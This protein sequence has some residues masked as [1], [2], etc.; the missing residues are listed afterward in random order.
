MR[1]F[2]ILLFSCLAF[3]SKA[4][5]KIMLM[6]GRILNVKNISLSGYTIAYR[7]LE[8]DKLRKIDTEKV[9]AIQYADGTE[10]LVFTPNPADTNEYTIPQMRMFIKGEQDATMYYK[11]NLNKGVAFAIG[12]GSSLLAIYGLV[13][14]PAY[15]TIIGAFSPNMEKMQVSDSMLLNDLDYRDGYKSKVRNRK[16]RNSLLS[17]FIGFATGAIAISLITNN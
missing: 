1:N 15:S 8:K 9:F 2:L 7:T 12:A 14:P 10:K 6:N 3:T 5:D 11:N 17:G 13:I 16:I 4:Q